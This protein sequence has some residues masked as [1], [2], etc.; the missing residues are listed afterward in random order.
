MAVTGKQVYD[1]AL[2]L[3]DEVTETG[4]VVTEQ[5]AYYQVKALHILTTLQTELLPLS[6][7]PVPIT[8]LSQNLL[9]SD[10]TA[11]LVLPYGL[12]AHLLLADDM[13]LAS[14]LNAR[15]D[16]LKRK[17]ATGGIQPIK[18]VYWDGEDNGTA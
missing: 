15:F 13:N 4:N 12:A 8:D 16:E 3:M 14:F 2:V 6:I 10:R 11:L 18:D 1:A 7:T 9:V 5:P 17:M